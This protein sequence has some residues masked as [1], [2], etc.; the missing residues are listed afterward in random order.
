MRDPV[1]AA[2][3]VEQHLPGAQ[4]VLAEPVGE[5]LAIVSQ[6]L[7][8]HPE[9]DQRLGQRHT[10]TARLVARST[11][12]AITQYREWSSTPVTTFASRSTPVTGLTSITPPTMSIPHNCIGAGRSQRP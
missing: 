6:D 1:P 9:P 5:L 8:G 11:T 2:N 7:L 12:F 4:T 10:H 3:L